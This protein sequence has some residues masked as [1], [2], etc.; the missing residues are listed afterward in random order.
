MCW[1]IWLYLD[2][3]LNTVCSGPAT[4]WHWPNFKKQPKNSAAWMAD[5]YVLLNHPSHKAGN[6]AVKNFSFM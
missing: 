1:E 3:I 4:A 2:L 6:L 5:C